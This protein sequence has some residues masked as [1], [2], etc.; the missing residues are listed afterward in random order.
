MVGGELGQGQQAL[1]GDGLVDLGHLLE[2]P[3]EGHVP[4]WLSVLLDWS[5]VLA[6]INKLQLIIN[7]QKI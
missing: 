6:L 2:K 5:E 3:H 7:L 1:H 4:K